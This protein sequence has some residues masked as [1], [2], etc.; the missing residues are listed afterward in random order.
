MQNLGCQMNVDIDAIDVLS[1]EGQK[2]MAADPLYV[3]KSRERSPTWPQ[4]WI[5]PTQTYI[6]GCDEL[7][8]WLSDNRNKETI[9]NLVRGSEW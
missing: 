7:M 8:K 2:R 5:T 1:T 6:G 9:K 3:R 4:I